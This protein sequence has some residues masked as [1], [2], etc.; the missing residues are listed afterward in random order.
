[1]IRA[2]LSRAPF[3]PRSRLLDAR[4]F[5]YLIRPRGGGT[6]SGPMSPVVNAVWGQRGNAPQVQQKVVGPHRT[7]KRKAV[8]R[9]DRVGGFR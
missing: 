8:E 2:V 6:P 1:M 9:G 5:G 4:S 7:A 3:R